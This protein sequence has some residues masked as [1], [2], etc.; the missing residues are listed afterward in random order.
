MSLNVELARNNMIE[1]QVRPWDVLD[2]RVLEAL[3]AL[4]REDFLPEAVRNLAFTD[5]E[6]PLGHGEIALKP[7]IEGRLLQSIAPA[8]GESVLEIGTGCGFLTAC[9]ARLG[10]NVTSVEQHVD[11]V[12]AA[13][14]HLATAGIRNV[15]IEHADAVN[16]Y[17]PGQQFD[18]M[19]VTGAV[20]AL[21]PRWR[22]WI[23]PGGRLLAIVGES[24]AQRAVLYVRTDGGWSE[25]A[26]FETDLPYLTHAAPVARFVL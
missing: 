21:P 14:A 3:S 22:E 12:E 4:R 20:A 23:K 1:Q 10:G 16:A 13:R 6:L 11:F 15:H 9:L 25:Q 2:E 26:L 8:K 5:I 19:L 18:V 24:P 17:Q 7:V